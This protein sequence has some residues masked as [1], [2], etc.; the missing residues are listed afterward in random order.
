[1]LACAHVS[2]WTGNICFNGQALSQCRTQVAL[3]N[4]SQ[5]ESLCSQAQFKHMALKLCKH[6]LTCY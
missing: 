5:H 2:S 6:V 4:R 1:M 3:P